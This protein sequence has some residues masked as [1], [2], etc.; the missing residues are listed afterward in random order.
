MIHC[1]LPCKLNVIM[2]TKHTLYRISSPKKNLNYP[3]WTCLF[4]AHRSP[5]TYRYY[6]HLT[7]KIEVKKA[8]W[9][10]QGHKAQHVAWDSNLT[11]MTALYYKDTF[12][13]Y[14]KIFGAALKSP[15]HLDKVL[16]YQNLDQPL[17][18]SE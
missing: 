6:V 8:R 1:W 14:T 12:F 17:S 18:H 13:Y 4:K 15:L 16:K 11:W 9:S 2:T 7:D 5:G 10:A 3:P